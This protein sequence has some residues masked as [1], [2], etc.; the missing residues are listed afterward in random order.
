MSNQATSIELEVPCL[1][2]G[3]PTAV[4]RYAPV[5]GENEQERDWREDTDGRYRR[6]AL[7]RG[8]P[9]APREGPVQLM[10]TADVRTTFAS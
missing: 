9:C 7:L 10:R 2:C 3:R 8:L 6:R 4:S 1:E 5:P